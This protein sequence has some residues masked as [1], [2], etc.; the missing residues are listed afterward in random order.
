M[1]SY[2]TVVLDSMIVAAHRKN[3]GIRQYATE[4]T[5]LILKQTQEMQALMQKTFPR[6]RTVTFIPGSL[7]R[8]RPL[9]E[10]RKCNGRKI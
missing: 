1:G 7:T 9:R 3:E 2:S 10:R 5:N 4:L 8:P 6:R